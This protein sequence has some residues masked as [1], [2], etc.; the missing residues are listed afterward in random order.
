MELADLGFDNW[1][2]EKRSE[3][4]PPDCT[5]VRVT[6]RNNPDKLPFALSVFLK[7]AAIALTEKPVSVID[8]Q[9]L[10]PSGDKHDYFSIAP[11]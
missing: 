8:K 5:V 6:Y 1:F 2:K 3:Q 11:Y 9:Q 4:E 7:E 10:P